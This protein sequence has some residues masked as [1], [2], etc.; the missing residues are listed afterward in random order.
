MNR[1][2]DQT[3]LFDGPDGVR[4]HDG[5][6]GCSPSVARSAD[7]RLWF[8]PWDGVSV[9][10]PKRLPFNKLPPPVHVEQISADR[11]TYAVAP[12]AAV[13]LPPRVRD[14]SIDYTA[15]SLVGPEKSTFVTARRLGCGL[16]GRWHAT[17]GVL[18]KSASTQLPVSCHGLE[19]QR[20]LERGRHVR[21]FLGRPRVIPDDLVSGPDGGG[22][23]G[24]TRCDLSRARAPG[25]QAAERAVRG[26][27]HRAHPIAQELHDT[28]LQGF[29]SASM[30]LHVAVDRLPADSPAKSSLGRVH[31]LMAR[32]IE[33]GRNA[34]RG[35]R[36]ADASAEDLE[37]RPRGHSKGARRGSGRHYRVIIEGQPRPFKPVIRDEVY[38]IG[39]EAVVNAF[40][41]AE[42]GNIE[43]ELDYRPREL[44]MFVRDDGRGI[45]P[46]VVRSGS[47]GHWGLAGMRERARAIGPASRSRAARARNGNRA[48]GARPCRVRP[49][50]ARPRAG[51]GRAARLARRAHRRRPRNGE[52][53]VSEQG[54][55][56]C[57]AWTTIRCCAKASPR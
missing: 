18:W 2:A 32:V 53:P 17:P 4:S 37:Q 50:R 19:Q 1:T 43:V 12:D 29:V 56:A 10:D 7:G 41:H 47:D 46:A 27:A 35:L 49:R 20:G 38:R 51:G 21:E 26:T 45:D 9:V 15:L 34:V 6:T 30:Q 54:R 28:L 23:A 39:R 13:H 22:D 36:V 11:Q 52:R 16:A 44:R 48:A 55:S 40:R 31:E 8:L 33:E 57:S 25:R 3:T 5:T 42:A 14:V 24:H